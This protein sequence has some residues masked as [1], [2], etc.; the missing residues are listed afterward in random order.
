MYIEPLAL[1]IIA[2]V[3]VVVIVISCFLF[4]KSRLLRVLLALLTE[5]R[6]NRLR[7]E[8][9]KKKELAELRKQNKSLA[10]EVSTFREEGQQTYAEQVQQRLDDLENPDEEPEAEQADES[11]DEEDDGHR[12]R[13]IMRA[14]YEFEAARADPDNHDLKAAED[15]LLEQLK[16]QLGRDPDE[17]DSEEVKTQTAELMERV[18]Y[19]EPFEQQANDLSRELEQTQETLSKAQEEIEKL[20]E[21]NDASELDPDAMPDSVRDEQD[22]IYR[23]K[24]ERFDM[25]ESI[26]ALKLKLQKMVSDGD[27]NDLLETQEEQIR[28]QSRYIADSEKSIALLEEELDKA[29]KAIEKLKAKTDQ[30]PDMAEFKASEVGREQLDQLA[31]YAEEQK[32][33]MEEMR[34]NL[35]AIRDAEKAEEREALLK[36]Q[37]DKLESMQRAVMESDT[38]VSMMENELNE[39][40]RTID[41]LKTELDNQPDVDEKALERAQNETRKQSEQ[42]DALDDALRKLVADSKDMVACVTGL[43]NENSELRQKLI[44]MG[45]DESELPKPQPPPNLSRMTEED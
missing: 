33:S 21:I 27:T 15:N 34:A 5:M 19:L 11:S 7:R 32:T 18:E 38:C 25:A 44:E 16:I 4:Y 14:F 6:M 13:A 22:E 41:Q 2:E 39:A 43:D 9:K 31:G 26:N 40:N 1:F 28:Q 37:E 23:L 30:E 24:C 20:R 45:V 3:V 10:S 17:E 12:T 42:A 35:V 36:Q 29:N 8:V